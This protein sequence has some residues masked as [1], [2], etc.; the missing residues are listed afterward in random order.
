MK[1]YIELEQVKKFRDEY[2]QNIHGSGDLYDQEIFFTQYKKEVESALDK[3]NTWL[4]DHALIANEVFAVPIK[5]VLL[6]PLSG[7]VM[8][9]IFCV[10][11]DDGYLYFSSKYYLAILGL[12]YRMKN[13]KVEECL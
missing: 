9:S 2:R 5:E 12:G 6:H 4:E 1:D 7:P 11:R 10:L 13:G 3:I 8:Q